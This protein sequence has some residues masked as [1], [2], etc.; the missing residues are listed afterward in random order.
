MSAAYHILLDIFPLL[1]SGLIT[2]CLYA[3]GALGLVMI[4]KSSRVVNFSHGNVAGLAAFLIYGFSSGTLLTLSWSA[5]VLMAVV[6]VIAIAFLSYAIVAPI[7]AKSDLTATIATLSLGLIAQG[8]TLLVFGADIVPLDLPLPRFSASLLGLRITGYDLTVLAVAVATIVGLFLVIDYTKLGVAF[9]AI[10]ANPIAAE[11]CGL[12]LRSVHLFAWTVSA[13]LGVIGALLIVPTTFL[14]VTTV[15]TFM[16][17]AFA[18]AVLGGFSSLPGALVGG[19]AIG[20]LMNLFTF[21]VSPEFTNT[22]LLVVILVALN[23]FPNGIFASTG[24]TRV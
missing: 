17:Q 13:V 22:F 4:F 21:Y 23:V 6:A 14:S 20:I 2:G 5:A 11:I 7:M 8:V 10:S 24:G 18:A 16:L 12:N 3:L 1:W 9:R 15:A 19:I